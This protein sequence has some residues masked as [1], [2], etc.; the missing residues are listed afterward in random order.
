M[1]DVQSTPEH[2]ALFIATPNDLHG[3]AFSQHAVFTRAIWQ[4]LREYS[5]KSES[6]LREDVVFS[7]S[8]ATVSPRSLFV[9]PE[10]PFDVVIHLHPEALCGQPMSTPGYEHA[11]TKPRH[12]SKY[13]NIK[14]KSEA[15]FSLLPG[16]SPA[17]H[18]AGLLHARLDSFATV[19]APGL[20][21]PTTHFIGLSWKP[22]ALEP[23][24][25]KVASVHCA[26]PVARTDGK[27][28]RRPPQEVV[29]NVE[30]VVHDLAAMGVGLVKVIT[31]KQTQPS[32]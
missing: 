2:P 18:Y 6:V 14:I 27:K 8:G 1:G 25:L 22:K 15:G 28:A 12:K 31:Q 16:L 4:R 13:K 9:T 23:Q 24:A 17:E 32:A 30:E 26:K 7:R 3:Q 19:F 11:S 10:G 29:L 20:I 21:N 5:R